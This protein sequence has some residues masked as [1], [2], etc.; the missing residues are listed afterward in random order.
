[1]EKQKYKVNDIVK[2]IDKRPFTTSKDSK[3][4]YYETR[5]GSIG[6]IISVG[7]TFD[8]YCYYILFKNSQEHLSQHQITSY[9]KKINPKIFDKS[10]ADHLTKVQI[11]QNL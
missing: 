7:K 5:L 10:M 9:D 4:V 2:F 8:G 3:N 11:L 1:M 6:K